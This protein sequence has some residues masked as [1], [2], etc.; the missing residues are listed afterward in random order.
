MSD[1]YVYDIESEQWSCISENTV[2][3]CGP[4]LM[5]DHQM[6][7]DHATDTIFVIGG[8]RVASRSVQFHSQLNVLN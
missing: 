4:G 8:R 1:F 2:E 5:F 6:V 3:D 7:L